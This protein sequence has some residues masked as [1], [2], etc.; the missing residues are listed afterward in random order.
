MAHGARGIRVKR[1]TLNRSTCKE[2]SRL[3]L[4]NA[5]RYRKH[6]AF[7][8]CAL[9]FVLYSAG[10]HPARL[11]DQRIFQQKA[12]RGLKSG[13]KDNKAAPILRSRS[14]K[15]KNK[16][17][18]GDGTRNSVRLPRSALHQYTHVQDF[19]FGFTSSLLRG[20]DSLFLR[21]AESGPSRNPSFL[22]FIL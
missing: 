18:T 21:M 10:I 19:P 1:R 13:N 8:L 6:A 22:K 15:T 14:K 9:R 4:S 3:S 12:T 11:R 16:R 5:A 2:P 7:V 20:A 17:K